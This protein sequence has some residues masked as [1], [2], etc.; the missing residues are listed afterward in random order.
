MSTDPNRQLLTDSQSIEKAQPTYGLVQ[1]QFAR[2]HHGQVIDGFTI[3]VEH[4][5][6]TGIESPEPEPE[7]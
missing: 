4:G 5:K 3:S 6:V 2:V 1:S 7:D